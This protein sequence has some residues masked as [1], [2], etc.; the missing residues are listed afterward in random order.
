MSGTVM[1]EQTGESREV[2]NKSL[3]HTSSRT[4]AKSLMGSDAR[5]C[6]PG[7][8]R[9]VG[10]AQV[11]GGRGA[12]EE[13]E[14]T[15]VAGGSGGLISRTEGMV[16]LSHHFCPRLRSVMTKGNVIPSLFSSCSHL[17]GCLLQH[18]CPV[19]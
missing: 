17:R 16:F 12:A 4:S 9:A 5:C 11:A 15:P 1:T 6:V 19:I 3:A 2:I 10:S 8:G 14:A 7:L 13:E 18:L